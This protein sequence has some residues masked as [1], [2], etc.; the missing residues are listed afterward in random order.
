MTA[1]IDDFI[2]VIRKRFETLRDAE[3]NLLY[4][5]RSH[6]SHVMKRIL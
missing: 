2:P 4:G 3:G 1:T 5:N 6:L